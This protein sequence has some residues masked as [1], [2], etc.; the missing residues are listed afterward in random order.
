VAPLDAVGRLV[1]DASARDPQLTPAAQDTLAAL[2]DAGVEV[3]L[4]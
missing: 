3:D 4:A 2:D 1:T